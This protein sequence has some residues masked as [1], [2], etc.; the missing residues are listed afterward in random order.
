MSPK[1]ADE[2]IGVAPGM[3][4]DGIEPMR[5]RVRWVID[6]AAEAGEQALQAA[7]E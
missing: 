6:E 5:R 2:G 1:A 4:H 7:A 3:P